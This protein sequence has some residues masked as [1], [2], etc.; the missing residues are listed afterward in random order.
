MISEVG[1]VAVRVRDLAAAEEV[2]TDLMGLDV[3]ERDAGALWLSHGAPHHS[4]QY[5]AG[6]TDAIDHIGLV[7][8]D[9]DAVAEVRARI[10][11]AGCAVARDGA[12]GPGVQDGFTFVGPEGVAF[13]VYSEMSRVH[14][15]TEVRGVRPSRL[16][17]VNL[18]SRDPVAM[19]RFLIEALDFRVSDRAGDGA[20]LR[21][22]VDHHG[23]GVFPGSGVLHHYAWEV[24]SI[25]ELGALADLVDQRGGSVLWGPMRHGIGRNVATYFQ[26]PSGLVV[27]YYAD[28]ERIYDDAHHE[29]TDW[30]TDGHKWF[31]LWGPQPLPDGFTELGLPFAKF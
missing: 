6:D 24:P 4:L 17:H 12:C 27:E 23:I 29:P 8:P 31:S 14:P 5:V 25:I 28:I 15:G 11:A 19:Q 10:E 2:A 1:H 18:F 21:C 30:D 13:A 26:E 7:A 3:T 20:F 16:G 22:N 9:A